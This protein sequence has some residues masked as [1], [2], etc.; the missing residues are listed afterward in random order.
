MEDPVPTPAIT[1]AERRRAVT[2]G[3]IGN[4]V[5]WFDFIAYGAL[6]V[7]LAPLFFPSD[8]P[9][10]SMLSVFAAF[11]IA[12]VCRPLGGIIWGYIGDRWGRRPALSSA[13]IVMSAATMTIGLLPTAESIGALAAIL[14]VLCRCI[15][16]LAAGGEWSGS[17]V[18]L[19]EFGNKRR[20]ALFASLT[21]TGAWLG[22][23]AGV[24]V[25]GALTAVLCPDAVS[26]WAWRIPFLLAGPLGLVGFYLRLKLQDTPAFEQLKSAEVVE[27]APIRE[28]LKTHKKAIFIIFISAASQATATYALVAFMVSYLTTHVGVSLGTALFTNTVALGFAAFATVMAGLLADRFGRKPVYVTA[29]ALMMVLAVPLFLLIGRGDIFSLLVGQCILAALISGMLAPI[30]VLCVELFPAKVRYA[31]SAVGYSV[32]AGLIGGASPLIATALI[33]SSGLVIAPAIYLSAV[34]LIAL[35]VV[36]TLLHETV[37]LPLEAEERTVVPDLERAPETVA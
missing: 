26:D 19:V 29:I 15:Q 35:V 3:A 25:V 8:S 13:V 27:K 2:A 32:G 10:A 11:A 4:F 7:V 21:P 20:R 36:G 31:A 12:F 9:T 33:A 16:G 14:L 37:D 22:S 24:A 28:A 34:L 18:Y 6:A 23:M 5:E 17:A 1:P 30:A